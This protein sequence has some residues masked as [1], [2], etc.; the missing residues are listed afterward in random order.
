MSAS[1]ISA[2]L[3][4]YIV[5][6]EES[7]DIL[8]ASL[9]RA[10]TA[11]HGG[12]LRLGGIGGHAMAAAGITSPFPIDE[13]SII[14]LTAIPRRLPQIFRRIREA[15]DAVVAARP[16]A[17][18]IIDS[19][20]FTHRIA[21]RVRR[22]AP[23]IP[24]LDYVSPSVWA[25]RPWRARAMRAY[26][27]HVLAIL[28]FE[29]GVHVRLGGPPCSYVG[30]PLV[31]RI[32]ELRP[33][34][35]AAQRRNTEPPLVLVLPGSRSSEV[36][37]LLAIFGAAIEQVAQRAGALELVLPTVPHVIDLVREGTATWA[38][39]PRIVVDQAEKMAAFRTARAALAA[40]GTVTLELA[41]AG[42][43]TVAAYRVPRIEEV[44]MRL[45]AQVK[46]VIL[47]NLVIGEHIVPEFLQNDCTPER[48]AAALLRILP[49]SPE[50]RRQIDAFARLDSI[51]EI[52]I[53]APSAKTADIV[54]DVA[55]RGRRDA[56][57]LIGAPRGP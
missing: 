37:R 13:L 49:D 20:E 34:T 35:V 47:T 44:I 51:M 30:H 8:G 22:V 19:P 55:R 29:P 39:K 32:A 12:E 2:P 18:V 24:I 15:A 41:L 28:P 56:A 52:G 7:G 17:L 27:D 5:A 3:S 4:I 10:L 14:G 45:H 25:W 33:D 43:P 36:R 57:A 42:V 1:S 46:T 26:V 38:V 53:A 21:R 31:E 54:L 23:S 16:N 50:R 6:A 9:A 40:S 11:R 48:L